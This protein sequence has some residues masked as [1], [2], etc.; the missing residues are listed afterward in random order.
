MKL[1]KSKSIVQLLFCDGAEKAGWAGWLPC[2]L[3]GWVPAGLFLEEPDKVAGGCFQGD[4]TAT[5]NDKVR[6]RL[7]C[8][9]DVVECV[10][11]MSAHTLPHLSRQCVSKSFLRSWVAGRICCR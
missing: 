9:N 7:P 3:G 8:G 6:G 5:L 1:R 2:N 4:L 11:F 10:G